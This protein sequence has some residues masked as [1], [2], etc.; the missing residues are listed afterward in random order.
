MA[1]FLT[2][3]PEL[4]R[5]DA[6][7]V[8]IR[9]D[10]TWRGQHTLA[11]GPTPE[12]L[13]EQ[14]WGPYRFTPGSGPGA[15]S[16]HGI[17]GADPTGRTIPTRGMPVGEELP[18]HLELTRPP[19]WSQQLTDSWRQARG[20]VVRLRLECRRDGREPWTLACEIDTAGNGLRTVE[21]P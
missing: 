9:D 16:V 19:T 2:G 10:H 4:E 6:L 7:T 15:D 3:P 17:P 1:V 18:F 14:I 13:A 8:T 5:L 12:Q 11:G 21:V 20:S